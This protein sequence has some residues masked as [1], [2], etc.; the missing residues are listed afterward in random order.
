MKAF[1]IAGLLL[2]FLLVTACKM[3]QVKTQTISIPETTVGNLAGNTVAVGGIY[4]E[5]GRRVVDLTVNREKMNRKKAGDTLDLGESKWLITDI[6]KS[7][8]ARKGE[9]TFQRL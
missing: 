5:D 4:R 3:P 6:R 9:V 7:F 1:G 8:F 2:S